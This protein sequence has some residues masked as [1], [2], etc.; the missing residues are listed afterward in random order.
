MILSIFHR[1]FPLHNFP[2][3][4][5]TRYLLPPPHRARCNGKH[6]RFHTKRAAK[7]SILSYTAGVH[8]AIQNI[9]P[10]V[11]RHKIQGLKHIIR[12]TQARCTRVRC[13]QAR[14][15]QARCKQARCTQAQCT[16]AR[17]TQTPCTQAR[18]TQ[19]RCTQTR[20]T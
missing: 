9:A 11:T 6:A 12:S 14:C 20:C 4:R 5:G 15:M 16:Q 7:C 1:V 3:Y 19:A 10:H 13:T 2:V 8:N 18:C 17:C